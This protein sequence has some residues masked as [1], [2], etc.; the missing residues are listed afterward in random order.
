MTPRFVLDENVVICAQKGT[1]IY[2]RP[3]SVCI[4]LVSRIIQVCHPMY[5]DDT[6]W[7]CY[8]DQLN[9]SYQHPQFGPYIMVALRNALSIAD[10]LNGLGTTAPPFQGEETIPQG[11]QDDTY[12]VRI[13][14]ETGAILVTADE[15]LR[16][17]LRECGLMEAHDLTVVS[18]E[19]ALNLI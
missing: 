11:S 17:D 9:R 10:K 6:L 1:D 8:N 2:E 13:A 16:S 14:V 4:D 12:L 18:P 19:D 3:S 15:A 5:V 7:D